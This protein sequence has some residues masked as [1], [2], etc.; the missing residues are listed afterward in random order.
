[1]A[2]DLII[3]MFLFS[4]FGLLTYIW[5]TKYR[6]SKTFKK[7]KIFLIIITF[8]ILIAEGFLIFGSFI[9]PRRLIINEQ[10]IAISENKTPIKIVFFSDTHL[11]PYNNSKIVNK[12]TK[13]IQEID[14]DIV[15]IGG[16]YISGNERNAHHLRALKS[17]S[18][19]YPVYAVWGNHDFHVGFWIDEFEDQTQIARKIFNEIGIKILENE[20]ILLEIENRNF[21]LLGLD[22]FLA[23]R[24]NVEMAYEGI[25]TD[26]KEIKIVL[27]HNPDTL[28]KFAQKN[29]DVDIQLSGHTHGGQI[30]FPKIG[31]LVRLPIYVGQQY[32]QGLFDY[33][34]YKLFVTSGIGSIGT[35]ARLFNPPEIAVL[36]I[37]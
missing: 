10:K 25:P 23:H 24:D 19:N 29:I 2:Y 8:L 22:S 33:N 30:R 35:R 28:P 31:S 34:K 6:E 12:I 11:G 9:E 21:W 7:Y 4:G 26:S 15:L 20:N 36:N 3:F 27:S 18:K 1:M 13:K 5:L 16:D 37:Y 32:D 17:I 14:P